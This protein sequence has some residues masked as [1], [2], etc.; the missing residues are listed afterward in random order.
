MTGDWSGFDAFWKAYPRK[1]AKGA[2]EKAW[3]R[4]KPSLDVQQQIRD[5]LIWQVLQDQWQDVKF[6][7]HPSTYLNQRR[8]EDEPPVR[9][10]PDQYG[11]YPPCESHRV[12]VE[13]F[14]NEER[15]KRG[16]A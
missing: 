4:L 12:C 7:P 13:R 15:A 3:K 10:R 9:Q 5:A 11:H 14:I 8:W 6:I 16:V 1:V 2:A